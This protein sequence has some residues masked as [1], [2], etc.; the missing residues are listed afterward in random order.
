MS[1]PQMNPLFQQYAERL[2][3]QLEAASAHTETPLPDGLVPMRGILP[4]GT[5]GNVRLEEYEVTSIA[6]V[7]HNINHA[8]GGSPEMAI[9]PGKYVRLY[10]GKHL[11]MSDAPY[12]AQSN[13]DIIE[14]A[15]GKV[16]IAG[17]GMGMV[18]VPILRN[19]AVTRVTVV[20]KSKDVIKLVHK[21]LLANGPFTENEKIKLVVVHGDINKFKPKPESYDTIYFDIWPSISTKNLSEITKL[22]TRFLKS[23]KFGG[24]MGVWVE[25]L[26]LK[27]KTEEDSLSVDLKVWNKYI[28][29]AKTPE[30]VQERKREVFEK[31][32][33][34]YPGALQAAMKRKEA[35][36]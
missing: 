5:S 28:K 32:S 33:V 27:R 12:E 16:L 13:R 31:L 4:P 25:D 6:A 35:Q 24:W 9:I 21:P 30:E 34:Q 8:Q 22:K 11:M 10:V 1:E 20:E 18:L 36:G 19:P 29:A 15:R 7:V 3:K 17:L 23:L 14:G 2:Q 26:I